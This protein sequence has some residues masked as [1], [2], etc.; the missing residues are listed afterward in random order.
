MMEIF[1]TVNEKLI[2]TEQFDNGAWINLVSPNDKEIATVCGAL[3]LEV[4]HLKAALDE[5]ESSRIEVDEGVT[6]IIVDIPISNNTLSPVSYSTLPLGIILAGDSIVTVCLKENGIIT[7]FIEN[8]VKTFYTFKKTRFILQILYR[9]AIRYLQY[10]RQIDKESSRIENE[11][12]KSM[13]NKEL[14]QL[15]ALEKSLVYFSTS[16]KANELV[17]EKLMRQESIKNYPDDAELL[18]D[19]IIEN[20]Q[21]IEMAKIYSDILSGTMDAFASVISNNLNIV[22]K[23]LASITIVMAIP[24]MIASFFGMNVMMPL[25][26]NHFAFAYI[27]GTTL[28]LCVAAA[29]VMARRKMF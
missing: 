16:L 5:E 9:N 10:L 24:T 15:L 8:K 21:A 11:L 13:K 27:L 26:G 6:L 25:Q 28:L 17:L 1:K 2:R 4:D 20:K 18:E 14:I 22:M 29:F 7:D 12:H 19:V 23:F 3:N